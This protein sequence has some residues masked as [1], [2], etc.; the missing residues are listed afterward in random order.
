MSDDVTITCGPHARKRHG[1]NHAVVAIASVIRAEDVPFAL[2]KLHGVVEQRSY[3]HRGQVTWTEYVGSTHP[4]LMHDQRERA[5]F[6]ERWERAQDP[7]NVVDGFEVAMRE[8]ALPRC[9]VCREALPVGDAT[10]LR[11][12][13]DKLTAHG[14]ESISL[15]GLRRA[16]I[17]FQAE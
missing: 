9:P 5:D 3:D 1:S 2:V 11:D 7:F 17:A 12:L 4:D 6:D 8:R 14:V 15:S 10:E 16:R 13:L